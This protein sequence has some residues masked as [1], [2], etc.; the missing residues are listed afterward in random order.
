M[1]GN[2]YFEKDDPLRKDI[3]GDFM[4]KVDC[5]EEY[6]KEQYNKGKKKGK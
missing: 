3:L 1:L 2:M 6:G 5:I 4:M